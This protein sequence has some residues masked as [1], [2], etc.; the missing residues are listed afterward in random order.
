MDCKQYNDLTKAQMKA[1]RDLHERSPDGA[2]DYVEFI[3][4]ANKA[5]A[6]DC[7]MIKWCGMWIGIE[8]DGYTHS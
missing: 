4:R 1:L 8:P 5:L 2:K 3:G 6:V 7:I